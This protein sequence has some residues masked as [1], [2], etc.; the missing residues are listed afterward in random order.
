MNEISLIRAVLYQPLSRSLGCDRPLLIQLVIE[1]QYAEVGPKVGREVERESAG[2]QA[3]PYGVVVG[4]GHQRQRAQYARV[5]SNA[6][7]IESS[8]VDRQ[9]ASGGVREFENAAL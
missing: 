3:V 4:C 7:R 2:V 9:Y 8:R 6:A 1:P 5:R